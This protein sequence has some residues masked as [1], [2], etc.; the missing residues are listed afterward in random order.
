MLDFDGVLVE[1]NVEKERAFEDLFMLY[2]AFRDAMMDYHLKHY[3][4]P[5]MR[6]FEHY[7]FDLMGHPGDLAA[8]RTM[9]SQFSE[10]I[11]PRVVACSEVP[12]TRVFLEEFSAQVPLYVSSVTPQDELSRIINMR[13]LDSFFVGV[14]GD[15]PCAKSEAIRT[16]LAREKLSATE[17]MFV[18]DSDA[19][20]RAAVAAGLEFVGRDSG[21]P[22]DGVKI[23]LY[24]DLYEISDVVRQRMDV[25][26][27]G[28]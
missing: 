27:P 15:P 8:V 18:G 26:E 22:F 16:V 9:G 25:H 13:G 6:K 1:S 3:S 12:G 21:L 17:V 2:P 14:F 28:C 19:D 24:R 11:M 7:V 20:Y 5:R 4:S 10:M 23:R